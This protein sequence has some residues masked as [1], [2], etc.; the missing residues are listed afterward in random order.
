MVPHQVKT[1]RQSSSCGLVFGIEA[2]GE[3][4]RKKRQVQAVEVDWVETIDPHIF[5]VLVAGA[6]FSRKTS[7]A[8]S[9]KSVVQTE[10]RKRWALA[11][12]S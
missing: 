3:L 4:A 8:V 11:G 5:R 1:N 7:L 2:A 10:I 9:Q 12:R 6:L